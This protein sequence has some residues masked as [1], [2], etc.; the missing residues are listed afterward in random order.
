[1]TDRPILH[2]QLSDSCMRYRRDTMPATEAERIRRSRERAG[3]NLA[4]L[5]I[6]FVV[7]A[8][9]QAVVS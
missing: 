3:R 1:M 8:F 4:W 6:G 2:R 7:L 5:A 9:G